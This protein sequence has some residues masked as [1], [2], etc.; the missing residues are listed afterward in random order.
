MGKPVERTLAGVAAV[1]WMG[2]IYLGS[3]DL[4]SDSQTSRFVGPF[5][6]WLFPDISDAT[7]QALRYWIRKGGHLTEYAILAGLV[8]VV[9]QGRFNP[10]RWLWDAR[11]IVGTVV[12]CL[13]YAVSDEWHQS[14]IPTRQGSAIDVGIDVA[15]AALGLGALWLLSRW[16]RGRAPNQAFPELKDAGSCR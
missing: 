2:L 10:T 16:R 4:L 6:R 7:T 14:L 15:G 8:M 3:T 1:A 5:L 11:S 9:V 13:L 12:F